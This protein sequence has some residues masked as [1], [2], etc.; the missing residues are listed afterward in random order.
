MNFKSLET[1]RFTLKIMTPE[2]VG[3]A[4]LSWFSD[5]SLMPFIVYS[6][7]KTSLSELQDYVSEKLSSPAAL[8]FGIFLRDAGHHIGNIKFEPLDFQSGHGVMG[9]LLGDPDWRGRGVFSEISGM[10]EPELKSLGIDRLYLGVEKENQAA[11]RAYQKW[12]YE[13]DVENR[14]NVELTS[15]FCMLKR[16]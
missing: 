4:Y 3:P 2:L 11:V 16:L 1:D 12:G 14:M 8:M 15:Q 5:E 9:I 7:E 13:M 10:I 6:R